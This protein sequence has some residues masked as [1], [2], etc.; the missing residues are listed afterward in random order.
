MARLHWEEKSPNIWVSDPVRIP[1]AD[2]Y[3][4]ERTMPT[5]YRVD[6][7]HAEDEGWRVDELG[8]LGWEAID[9]GQGASSAATGKALAQRYHDAQ[10]EQREMHPRIERDRSSY[11]RRRRA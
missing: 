6:G 10:V 3:G 11:L 5:R 4:R 9:R 1:F 7:R 2:L 8:T